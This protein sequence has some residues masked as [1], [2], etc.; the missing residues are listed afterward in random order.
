MKVK[1][2]LA[3]KYPRFIYQSY[4][5]KYSKDK[6]TVFFAFKIEPNIVFKP[7]IVFSNLSKHFKKIDIAVLN[8]L[9][10]HLGMAEIP[11]YW[12]ATCSPEI[13]IEAGKLEREE[14]NFWKDLLIH[15]LGEFYY[16]NKIDFTKKNFIK[17]TNTV[18]SS[19]PQS[20]YGKKLTNRTL[21]PVG[22]GK[23]SIVTLEEIKVKDKNYNCFL[24]NPTKAALRVVKTAGCKNPIIVERQIDKK[25]LELNRQGYL[26]GHTPFSSYLAFLSVTASIL[27]DYKNIALSNE[28]SANEG[29]VLFHGKV[30]NHQYSKSYRFEKLF[31]EY[32]RKYL[33]KHVN[34]YSYLRPFD[35]L[36]IAERFSKYPQYFKVFRSC[37][38]GS[39]KGIWCN[40][41]SKCLF[42]YTMLSPFLDREELLEIFGEDLLKKPSLKK[43]MD[44]LLGIS[45]HKPFDCVG[46]SEEVRKALNMTSYKT[47]LV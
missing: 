9:A 6:L 27:Y 13:V 32:S 23:D 8:N 4:S 28:K 46:T 2:N 42:A 24:L 29:N 43:T 19:L 33:A 34:Y 10:F 5:L 39:K 41:C 22:G 20:I 12:K 21:V 36:Q 7:K 37:N 40:N 1:T 17:I 26:N 25:L 16:V 45:G 14:I 30:V 44:E 38:V 31:N 3:R 35:E 47:K 15:G 11:T 18:S